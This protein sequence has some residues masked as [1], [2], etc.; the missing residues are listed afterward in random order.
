M[1]DM[2]VI[3][4]DFD[5]VLNTEKHLSHL[6]SEGLPVMD[7]FGHLFD[8]EAIENLRSILESVPKAKIVIESSWKMMGLPYI[9]RM[10]KARN[11]PGEIYGATPDIS[12]DGLLDVDLSAPGAISR[13]EGMGKGGEIS[14][15]L[16]SH[17]DK[18]CRYVILDDVDEFF[19]EPARHHI[20]IH[21]SVGI[22]KEDARRAIELL[23][24]EN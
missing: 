4:L 8:P 3:F 9:K 13:L 24:L 15:W 6:R 23:C 1:K 22:T 20:A 5:G 19:G 16:R 12:D 7:S 11:L 10:W 2:K 21:P 18:E 14:A 17:A